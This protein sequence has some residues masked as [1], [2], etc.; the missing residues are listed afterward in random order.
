MTDS[1]RK[2]HVKRYG[3][4]GSETREARYEDQDLDS[5]EERVVEVDDG[6]CV[7]GAP[8]TGSKEE[9][10][11]CSSCDILCCHRCEVEISYSHLCPECAARDYRV[12]KGVFQLL[13]LVDHDLITLEDLVTVEELPG[14][15]TEIRVDEAATILVE[16]GFISDD[17]SSLTPTGRESLHVGAQIW[18]DDPDIREL[19]QN[20]R[21]KQVASRE[22]GK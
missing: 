3:S 11:R 5:L 4:R 22:G 7:C 18:G 15:L 1:Y 20:I 16:H 13:L 8:L 19:K 10:Y 14:D 9:V 2:N 12:D 21:V 17:D 6:F